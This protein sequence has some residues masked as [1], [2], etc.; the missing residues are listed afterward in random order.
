MKKTI[1]GLSGAAKLHYAYEM[2]KSENRPLLYITFNEIERAKAHIDL[3]SFMDACTLEGRSVQFMSSDI[4]SGNTDKVKTMYEAIKGTS[5]VASIDALLCYLAPK[6]E[7]QK[8]IVTL[9]RDMVIEL[10]DLRLKLLALGYERV[11][12]V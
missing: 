12:M 10:E 1:Y 2:A 7:F 3:C 6:E 4:R 8:A 5:I 11:E 9:K